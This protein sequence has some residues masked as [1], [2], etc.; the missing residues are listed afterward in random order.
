[1]KAPNTLHS[2]DGNHATDHQNASWVLTFTDDEQRHTCD[3]C[4]GGILEMLVKHRQLCPAV[5]GIELL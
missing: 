4:I 5:R 2:C 3:G 1:M